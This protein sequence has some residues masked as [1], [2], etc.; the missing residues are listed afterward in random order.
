M[1]TKAGETICLN[2]DETEMIVKWIASLENRIKL[3]EADKRK[4]DA[5][6]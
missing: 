6:E 1:N 2:S 3:L 5:H 4:E